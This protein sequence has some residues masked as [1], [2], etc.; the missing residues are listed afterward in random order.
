MMQHTMPPSNDSGFHELVESPS[1]KMEPAVDEYEHYPINKRSD[2]GVSDQELV[3]QS[4]KALNKMIKKRGISK[5]RAKQIKQE[6][7][8]L[9]NRG[10]A[11]NCRVKRENEEKKLE[12]EN[13]NLRRDICR[14][15]MEADRKRNEQKDLSREYDMID[16]ELESMKLADKEQLL[17]EEQYRAP[18]VDEKSEM[19]VDRDG[20]VDFAIHRQF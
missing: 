14:M 11:A 8:T 15:K 1:M 19:L 18:I 9:K 7:R 12:R 10:Y 20:P 2:I 6:R 16:H 3:M 13:E 4:T 17:K 5:E